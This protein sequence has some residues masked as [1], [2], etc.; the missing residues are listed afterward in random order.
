MSNASLLSEE[1][2]VTHDGERRSYNHMG[3]SCD[4][5]VT[6]LTYIALPGS[7][8]DHIVFEIQ[9]SGP[10]SDTTSTSTASKFGAYGYHLAS[11]MSFRAGD[12]FLVDANQQAPSS[13]L[14]YRIGEQS[15]TVCWSWMDDNLRCELDRDYPLL[16]VETGNDYVEH[17]VEG[18]RTTVVYITLKFAI[19]ILN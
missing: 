7:G 2:F 12:T 11:D 13:R 9:G 14:L 17:I 19:P 16:A 8:T 3:F 6:K 15:H 18:L 5:D 1:L 10:E 4:G